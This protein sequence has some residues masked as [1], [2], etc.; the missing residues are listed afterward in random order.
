MTRKIIAFMLTGILIFM[1]SACGTEISE[2]DQAVVPLAKPVPSYKTIFQST[3]FLGDSITEGLSYHD[4]LDEKNVKAGAGKTAEFSLAEDVDVLAARN[5][6]HIFIMLGSDDILWPTEN[7]RE[8]S[9]KHYKKLIQAIKDKIPQARIT[10]LSVTPVTKKAEEE[11]PRYKNI[12]G[13]NEGLK[14][15]AEQEGLQFAD[16]SPLVQEKPDL[17]D[18]D[19]IHFKP[20][21]YG[22]LL[23]FLKDRVQ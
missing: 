14:K 19:G 15:L 9:L 8:Y 7:P 6:K 23:D 2:K 18:T 1:I 22:L 4:F 17:Y 16:L 12:A 13:Y 3:V 5:P 11:E 21:F 20:E 10:I